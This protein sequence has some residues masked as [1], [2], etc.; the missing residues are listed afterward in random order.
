[1]MESRHQ[2]RYN[3]QT[4]S[5][6]GRAEPNWTEAN[7]S[8]DDETSDSDTPAFT[9]RKENDLPLG[10]ETARRFVRHAERTILLSNLSPGVTHAD[11][12][13]VIRGGQLLEVFV[14]YK[15]QSA[16]VSFLYEEDA[17]AFYEHATKYDLYI[18]QKRASFPWSLP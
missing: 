15:D 3:Q 17:R 8:S 14:R 9:R 10:H 1:M 11:I 12:T 2:N 5:T 4:E 16:T 6:R 7:E 13:A 18:R